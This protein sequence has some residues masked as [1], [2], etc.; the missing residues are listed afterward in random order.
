V[1]A[2]VGG[3]ATEGE[4]GED[5]ELELVPKV[6]LGLGL[7]WRQRLLSVSLSSVWSTLEWGFLEG[8]SL[9]ARERGGW[10]CREEE[11]EKG[12]VE[13]ERKR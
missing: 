10:S 6:E 7:E 9:F 1:D 2:G 5:L 12:V 13:G 3:E 4:E 11:A 8:K